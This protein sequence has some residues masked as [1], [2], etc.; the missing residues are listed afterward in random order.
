MNFALK[1]TLMVKIDLRRTIGLLVEGLECF[2]TERHAALFA[3]EAKLVP[4]LIE[5][6][7]LFGGVDNFLTASTVLRWHFTFK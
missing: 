6:F 7:E 2:D 1:S 5:A 4:G 3:L